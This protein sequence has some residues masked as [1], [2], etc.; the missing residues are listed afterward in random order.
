MDLILKRGF[1]YHF[2]A[3]DLMLNQE[4]SFYCFIERSLFFT[5]ELLINF[6]SKTFWEKLREY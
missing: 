6:R 3:I 2:A 1:P 4:F 5:V